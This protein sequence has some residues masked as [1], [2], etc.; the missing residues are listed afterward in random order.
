M[1]C[2][3][4]QRGLKGDLAELRRSKRILVAFR[5]RV[6]FV[7]FFVSFLRERIVGSNGSE[8]GFNRPSKSLPAHAPLKGVSDDFFYGPSGDPE[9]AVDFLRAVL[10]RLLPH[11]LRGR[12]PTLLHQRVADIKDFYS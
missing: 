4:P 1:S 11:V 7:Y 10:G 5:D 2:L 3:R 9:F 6:H 12:R 8:V